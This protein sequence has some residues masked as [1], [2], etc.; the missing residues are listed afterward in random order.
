VDG[1]LLATVRDTGIGIPPEDQERIFEE[2]YRANNARMTCPVGTGVGLAIVQRIIRNYGG[3]IWVESEPGLG[4][5]FTFT[6][7]LA[8]P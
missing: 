7:P 5:K 4:S 3:Q 8:E 1:Q 2:F 6:L